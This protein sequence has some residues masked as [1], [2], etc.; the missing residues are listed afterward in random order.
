EYRVGV[1]FDDPAYPVDGE[2]RSVLE[3][4]VVALRQ[5][6]CTVSDRRPTIDLP[7]AV[8]TYFQLLFP[9]VLADLPS[10]VFTHMVTAA[11]VAP[12]EA[13]DP[14]TRMVRFT[15]IRHGA[16]MAADE[17][18]QR[19]RAQCAEFFK[20]HDA[21][22]MPVAPVAAIPHDQSH[23]FSARTI[24]VDGKPRSYFELF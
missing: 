22:V 2:V 6:G 24:T 15:T 16:W 23:P 14:E 12:A 5:A 8:R 21:L 9:V 20:T 7:G 18:R 3:A 11:A 4:A 10:E 17:A 13:D 19:I 1:W